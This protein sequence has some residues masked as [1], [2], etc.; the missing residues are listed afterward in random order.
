MSTHSEHGSL[1]QALQNL[2][3]RMVLFALYYRNG[4]G[5]HRAVRRHDGDITS[6]LYNYIDRIAIKAQ[7]RGKPDEHKF[8][9]TSAVGQE[10]STSHRSDD[11]RAGVTSRSKPRALVGYFEGRKIATLLIP[12]IGNKLKN[13][14][15]EHLHEAIRF[16]RMGEIKNAKLHADLANGTLKEALQY[17]SREEFEEFL[18]EIENKFNDVLAESKHS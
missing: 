5:I 13:S 18:G 15:W 8:V 12:K 14:T 6:P 9:K 10:A 2:Y 11:V 4:H 3:S 7:P 1:I 16:G 17:M